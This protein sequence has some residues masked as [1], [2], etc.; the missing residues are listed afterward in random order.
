MSR[1]PADG[2]SRAMRFA[3]AVLSR[4]TKPG[5]DPQAYRAAYERRTYPTPPPVPAPLRLVARVHRRRVDGFD[6]FTVTP[7]AS[8]GR[9]TDW[10]I[11]YLHGGAYVDEML[12]EHWEIVLN[13]VRFTGATVTVPCYPLGPEHTHEVGNTFV[14]RVYRSLLEHLP[15][16]RIVLM[17]DSAGGGMCLVQAMRY[18]DQGLDPPARLI[19]FAPWADPRMVHPDIPA[20][21]AD[22]PI[23]SLTGCRIAA[24]WWAGSD[25]QLTHPHVNPLFADVSGLPPVDIYLGTTDILVPD[26][27]LMADK[28][29]AAGVEVT[30]VEYPGA[31][32]VH[33]GA[34]FTREARDTYRRI[35]RTLGAT[36]TRASALGHLVTW[37]AVSLTRQLIGRLTGTRSKVSANPPTSAARR[38][39][40]WSRRRTGPAA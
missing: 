34:T 27:R 9:S 31:I 10:H 15:A 1:R 38:Q 20:L 4:E 32:H 3:I 21:V 2:A 23:Q 26:V 8:L 24:R 19:V 14:E 13:L 17:G 18:R 12:S 28:L 25:D 22:D 33:V 29:A 16:E 5:D 36:A 37:P 35:A 6:V 30:L 40:A 39:A 7:K 11:V